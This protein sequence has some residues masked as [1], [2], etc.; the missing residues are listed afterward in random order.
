MPFRRAPSCATGPSCRLRRARLLLLER[1]DL[2]V[3]RLELRLEAL[4]LLDH[5]GDLRGDLHPS[6]PHHPP[7]PVTEL[8]QRVVESPSSRG[9]VQL[10]LPDERPLD[11]AIPDGFEELASH[12]PSRPARRPRGS[13]LINA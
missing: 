13:A 12:F 10:P 2:P 11:Q 7:V 6:C 8:P 3:L 1:L 9:P 5:P 4:H